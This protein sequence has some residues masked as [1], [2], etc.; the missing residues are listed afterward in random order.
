MTWKIQDTNV[1]MD[2]NSAPILILIGIQIV[3]LPKFGIRLLS[4][5]VFVSVLS[6]II[7]GTAFSIVVFS[8]RLCDYE[9]PQPFLGMDLLWPKKAN[10]LGSQVTYQCGYRT[11]TQTQ[12]LKGSI[13]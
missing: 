4:K 7:Q 8:A 3:Q 6:F 2:G 13:Q 5:H 10:I 1:L 12:K 9:P 11:G